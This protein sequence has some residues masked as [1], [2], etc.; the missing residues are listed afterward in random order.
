MTVHLAPLV[1]RLR[2]LAVVGALLSL[3]ACAVGPYDTDGLSDLPPQDSPFLRDLSR[4][5]AALGD[6]ERAEYD[7]PDTARFYDR[8]IRAAKGEAFPP[9]RLDDR[10]LSD[11]AQEELGAARARLVA[12]FGAGARSI[13]GPDSARGQ[14]AFDCWMQE[15][16]EGHQADDI[17]RCREIFLA[18]VTAIESAV[19]GALIVLL[20]DT[21][22]VVGMIRVETPQGSVVLERERESAVTGDTQSAPQ[23]TG[24]FLVADVEAVFGAALAAGPTPPVAF[25]LYFE[26]GT[27]RLTPDSARKLSEVLEVVGQ[28][29]LPQVE[30]SGH[31]DRS[32]SAAFNDQLAQDR[33]ELVAQEVLGLGVPERVVTVVSYGERAPVVPTADGVS[34]A[35][36][37]RV[38]IVVR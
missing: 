19:D 7:W 25:L 24:T 16:E 10:A 21:D 6:M 3:A 14:A 34:E 8:A 20:P 5:Y 32:G 9:E 18:A 17:A 36:N 4:E 2:R 1:L 13:V 38:E 28:R 27:D 37:R 35:R 12:L 31:T 29:K 22:G 30:V 26:Q 11:A 23:S 15:Q 33:A